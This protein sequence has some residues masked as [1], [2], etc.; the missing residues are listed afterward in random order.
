[1]VGQP[2]R[3]RGSKRGLVVYDQQMFLGIS[4]LGRA[5]VL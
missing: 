4:H 3:D 1:M 5:A 2:L